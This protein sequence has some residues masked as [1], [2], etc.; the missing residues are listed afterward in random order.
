MLLAAGS[1]AAAG[2]T[3]YASQPEGIYKAKVLQELTERMR[4]AETAIS[5][6]TLCALMFL[7]SFDVSSVLFL[8]SS[9]HD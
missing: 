8:V 1:L 4:F 5:D 9:I 6:E 2:D 7:T 3:E